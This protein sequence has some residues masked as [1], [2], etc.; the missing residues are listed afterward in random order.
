MRMATLREDTVLYFSRFKAKPSDWS[1]QDLAEF[2]RVES[3]LAQAGFPVEFDRGLTDEGDPWCAFCRSDT[4]EVVVHFARI[5]GRC[6]VASPALGL[7]LE[8]TNFQEVVRQFLSTLPAVTPRQRFGRD[9]QLFLHPAAMIVALVATAFCASGPASQGDEQDVASP[10]QGTSALTKVIEVIRA[11]LAWLQNENSIFRDNLVKVGVLTAIVVALEF[12]ATRSDERAIAPYVSH[13]M[14]LPFDPDVHV[15]GDDVAELVQLAK[16]ILDGAR[17]DQ[18]TPAYLSE[19]LFESELAQLVADRSGA[20]PTVAKEL[21]DIV[22]AVPSSPAGQDVQ[23]SGDREPLMAKVAA[24]IGAVTKIASYSETTPA[25]GSGTQGTQKLIHVLNELDIKSFTASDILAARDARQINPDEFVAPK[26]PALAVGPT[27]EPNGPVDVPAPPAE[28]A[29]VPILG[30]PAYDAIA[31]HV[32]LAFI[33]SDDDI[34]FLQQGG[35]MVIFDS[36][37]LDSPWDLDVRSWAFGLDTTI[38]IVGASSTLDDILAQY[39]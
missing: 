10:G 3:A 38:S 6:V 9:G 26:S 17:S 4:G 36:S 12:A 24:N 5:D 32:V 29:S 39:V 11:Q 15:G 20:A 1:N 21:P 23:P 34:R 28:R 18:A 19:A 37:D 7:S 25:D 8:G 13:K 2:Y 35:T 30:V 16:V 22:F 31:Q 14:E 27:A 33:K